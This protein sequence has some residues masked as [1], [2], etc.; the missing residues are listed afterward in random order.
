MK[1]NRGT[2]LARKTTDELESDLADAIKELN[3]LDAYQLPDSRLAESTVWSS[4]KRRSLYARISRLRAAL[5][6][7]DDEGYSEM[8]EGR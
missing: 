1:Y 4:K 5:R 2:R 3:R 8:V 6:I 7:K